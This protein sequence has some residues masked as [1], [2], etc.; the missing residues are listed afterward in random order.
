M[1]TLGIETSDRIGAVALVYDG[2][3]VE[4]RQLEKS[5]RR[6]AQTLVSEI[7]SILKKHAV[8][9]KDCDLVGV[10]VGPGSFTGLRIGVVFAKTFAY[11]TGCHVGA[12][13]S[14]HVLAQQAPDATTEIWAIA[15][16][17]R[18]ELFVGKFVK[19]DTGFLDPVADIEICDAVSWFRSRS[20]VE[21]VGGTVVEKY[22]DDLS[23]RVVEAA[24]RQPSAASVALLAERNFHA[25]QTD[26][27]WTLEPKYFRKSAA[28]EKWDAKTSQPET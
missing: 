21:L 3:C 5:G 8:E 17:Q 23:C 27:L 10:S 9:P 19:S 22:Q 13:N 1:W 15:D 7:D 12:V 26:D 6:H 11:A 2:Q 4:E 16:A 18:S 20:P 28:E 25:G 24:R 14:L